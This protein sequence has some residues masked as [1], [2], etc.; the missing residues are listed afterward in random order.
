MTYDIIIIGGGTA[1]MTA[2]VYGTRAGKKV[3]IL[4]G[5]TPGGQIVNA[6]HV[7]NYPGFKSISGADFAM[8]LF[9]QV[10][11]LGAVFAY[12]MV[13]GITDQG[14]VK[15]VQTA[16]H[17]YTAKAVIIAAGAKNRPLGLAG[18]ERLIGKGV[19]YCATCDGNF[20]KNKVTAVVGG[21]NTA[22][23][24][25]LFL[26]NVCKQVYLI[27]R[28]DSFR[29]EQHRADL[30]RERKNVSFLLRATVTGLFGDERLHTISVTQAGLEKTLDVDGLFVAI[31]Q[32][33]QNQIFAHLTDLDPAGY[34]LTDEECRTKTPG[35]FAAGDCRSKTVRQLSTAAAD[36]TIAALAAA[37]M[38]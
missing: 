22:L 12:E 24:D 6:A 25:A 34:I 15:T 31:G 36:G 7:E 28:R 35:I 11:G 18:E 38:E 2:A 9:D 26:S 23:E 30:L 21:G 19:S 5:E 32:M 3:L 20:F 27:H 10:K 37:Q 14:A 13:T 29:G 8:N 1:G 16:Q 17:T 33:P 4:E